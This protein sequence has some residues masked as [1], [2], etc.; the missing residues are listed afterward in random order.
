MR[1]ANSLHIGLVLIAVSVGVAASASPR[2]ETS[3]G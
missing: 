2:R 1:I 3:L